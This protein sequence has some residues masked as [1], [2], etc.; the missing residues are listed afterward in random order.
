MPQSKTR[1]L[2]SSLVHI[3]KQTLVKWVTNIRR[4]KNKKIEQQK[5][6]K[7]RCTLHTHKYLWKIINNSLSFNII[8]CWIGMNCVAHSLSFALCT[9]NVECHWRR[10]YKN[11][12]K[13]C[14][15]LICTQW[16]ISLALPV[17][18]FV[19]VSARRLRR[20]DNNRITTDLSYMY[21]CIYTH[22]YNSV[23]HLHWSKAKRS[24]PIHKN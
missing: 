9:R 14:V 17:A 4:K 2:L 18:V 10:R 1:H 21:R 7:K 24:K 8:L 16:W 13:S 23:V 19:W 3:W 6:R 12:N 20:V 5:T 15:H 22:G 11:Q